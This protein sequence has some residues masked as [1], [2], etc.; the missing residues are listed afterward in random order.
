M[1][2]LYG[3]DSKRDIIQHLTKDEENCIT[4]HKCLRGNVLWSVVQV[5]KTSD[6]FIACFLLQK[7]DGQWGYKDMEESMH[8]YYYTCPIAYL[9]E[10]PEACAAWRA[11][12]RAEAAKRA[13]KLKVG[14]TLVLKQG[15][16]P[17]TLV[18]I[19]VRPLRAQA[20]FCTYRVKRSLIAEVR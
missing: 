20:N 3:W 15:C 5:R 19:S 1:G 12:V 7:N 14:S 16:T 8:P 9:D 11:I 2:W 13:V 6:K 17:N 10:V 18:V 4:L